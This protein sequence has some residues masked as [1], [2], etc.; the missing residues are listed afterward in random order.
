MFCVFAIL[1]VVADAIA[2]LV[3][4][5]RRRDTFLEG[6]MDTLIE[7]DAPTQ[8]TVTA[9]A[10]A[11]SIEQL[12]E[13]LLRHFEQSAISRSVLEVLAFRDEGLN[14]IGIVEAVNHALAK[15]H[16]RELPHTVIRKIMMVLM[17]A[18][19][20]ALR[21]GSLR[22]TDAGRQLNALLQTRATSSP[23]P[24]AFVSP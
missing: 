18:N 8:G 12:G 13:N 7:T 15:E 16:K 20:V 9:P 5:P 6:L 3:V 22:L 14:E 17:R 11:T 21:Q 10:D 23:P 1:V 19:M 4:A 24:L 2:R